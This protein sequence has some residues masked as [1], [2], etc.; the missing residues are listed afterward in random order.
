MSFSRWWINELQ[1]IQMGILLNAKISKLSS[2][3]KTWKKQRL[4]AIW[5][6]LFWCYRK[7]KT[8]PTIKRSDFEGLWRGRDEQV[9]NRGFLG[10]WN[11]YDTVLMYSIH[12]IICLAKPTGHTTPTV[13][14]DV[15]CG[16][17]VMITCP[18]RVISCNPS[19]SRGRWWRGGRGCEGGGILKCHT[20]YLV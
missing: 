6:Q 9:E 20:F 16:L 8:M 7:G 10:Q 17:W 3:E 13:T 12:V 15:N 4:H 1:G 19:T 14:P 11:F 2:H 5:L 18:C